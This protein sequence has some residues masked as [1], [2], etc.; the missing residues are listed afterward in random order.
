M[1]GDSD[2]LMHK[3]PMTAPNTFLIKNNK[4]WFFATVWEFHLTCVFPNVNEMLWDIDAYQ[5]HQVHW[6]AHWY[7]EC[8][9]LFKFKAYACC[10]ESF[11][12]LCQA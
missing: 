1:L 9:T 4:I 12:G 10:Y 11:N 6:E 5:V 8:G 2:E 7:S 3:F